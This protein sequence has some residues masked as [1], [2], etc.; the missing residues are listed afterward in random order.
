MIDVIPAPRRVAVDGGPIRL[1]AGDVEY[2]APA[3][4]PL[5]ERFC[6]EATRRSG[7]R[8]YPE[9]HT[10]G[11]A[12]R[13]APAVRVSLGRHVDLAAIPKPVGV[14]PSGDVAP[15]E[16][17]SIR[18]GAEGI[19]VRAAEATGAARALA[20]L[21]QLIATAASVT[22]DGERTL[23]LPAVIIHDSPRFAWRGLT[24]DV[25]R[26][27][28]PPREIQRIIDLLALYKFN[29]LHLH[30][31][32]D[33]AWRIEAG[34]PLTHQMAD[35]TFYSNAELRHLVRYAEERCISV[36]PEADAPG[37]VKTLVHLQPT[38][39]SPRNIL[40]FE[41]PKVGTHR[42]AWLDPALP[43]TYTVFEK[44]LTQIADIFTGEYLHIGGDEPFGMPE[45]LYLEFVRRMRPYVL[46]L[47][48]R[49]IGFQES[50]RAI[51]DPKHVIQYWMHVPAPVEHRTSAHLAP[52]VSGDG[53]KGRSDIARAIDGGASIVVSPQT[54]SYFDVPYAEPSADRAQEGIR[55]RLGL[56]AHAPRTVAES[57]D[58][59]PS[60][61]LDVEGARLAGVGAAIWCETI[62][63]FNDLTFMLLPRLPGA[64][65]K[66]W[67]EA[68]ITWMDHSAALSA[69]R[70][71]WEQDGLTYF[72]SSTV[73][74]NRARQPAS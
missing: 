44:V 7:L 72:K 41:V 22:E 52:E 23:L 21:M 68:G 24:L 60:R 36:I 33:E 59:E 14:S 26:T 48:K 27:Y 70:R 71:L 46:A 69:H 54:N 35:R 40:S 51:T 20:T 50:A 34:R 15:D 37:H 6:R 53:R 66:A 30:L 12:G 58:W 31:T 42:S 8:L 55:T 18:I 10:L 65:Q 49:T 5:V 4:L 45:E 32:D 13:R 57:F 38:L 11:H 39:K 19:V 25:V 2:G 3:L 29:V 1:R 64:A 73:D 47:G 43:A 17:Y 67:G 62:K 61:L 63:S 9:R 56:R 16:R 28:F 74:W